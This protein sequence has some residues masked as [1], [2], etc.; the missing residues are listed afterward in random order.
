M[1]LVLALLLLVSTIASPA[2]SE[3]REVIGK[4]RLFTND[5]FGDGHDRWRSG[6]YVLSVV[7][8]KDAYSGVEAFGDIVEY[9]LGGQII[10]GMRGSAAPGDRPYAGAVSLGAHTHFNM[11]RADLSLGA[12]LMAIG[13]Q[14][15]LSDFQKK[16]HDG[17]DI[18]LPPYVDQQLGDV[19]FLNSTLEASRSFAVSDRVTVRPFVEGLA[20]AEN[21]VRL[22]G[23]VIVGSVGHN[24]LM[25]R[26]VVTGQ[27]Y[28]GTQNDEL[29]LS[30]LVGGDVAS[31]FSSAFLP[32]DQGYTVSETRARARAGVLFQFAQDATLFYGATYLSEEFEGQREGQV[33]GSLK[34]NFKF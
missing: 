18:P 17:F 28:R 7:T 34:L 25:L 9:R 33:V 26:D 32:E 11:A 4:G 15:G 14:T 24:D 5:F 3:G 2:F 1:R 6:S 30:Y 12:D 10:S 19:F 23:D 22:G 20:G 13:P 21:L 16:F 31:V 27:L 29:G 8:G